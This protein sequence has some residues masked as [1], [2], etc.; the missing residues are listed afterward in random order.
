MT[1][2][3]AVDTAQAA[4]AKQKTPEQTK[5]PP[6]KIVP[7]FLAVCPNCGVCSIDHYRCERYITLTIECCFCSILTFSLNKS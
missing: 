3:K 7:G 4:L 6:P 5:S 2:P 1:S